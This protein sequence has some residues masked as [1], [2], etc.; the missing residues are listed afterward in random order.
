[1]RYKYYSKP[2]KDIWLTVSNTANVLVMISD[3]PS[4]ISSTTFSS[5]QI[6]LSLT[7]SATAREANTR[8]HCFRLA[9][10]AKP[11]ESLNAWAEDCTLSR[12][13]NDS[14]N[15][16]IAFCKENKNLSSNINKSF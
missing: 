2:V 8:I 7:P 14:L 10:E 5:F 6:S 4:S 9:R 13:S 3:D 1:M 12:S 15:G 11:Q 16:I